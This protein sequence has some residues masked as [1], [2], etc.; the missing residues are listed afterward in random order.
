MPPKP[1][2]KS[3][4]EIAIAAC[5]LEAQLQAVPR[6][7]ARAL[8][9]RLAETFSG[10]PSATWIWEHLTTPHTSRQLEAD[11]ILATLPKLAPDAAQELL[12]FPESD[13]ERKTAFR[14]TLD[15][16]VTALGACHWFEYCITPTDF[17]WLV[18]ENHHD[19]LIAAGEPVAAR[20]DAAWP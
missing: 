3:R 11:D 12:V 2:A 9:Q 15:A 18:C 8:Y 7:E 5:G 1:P 16:I 4:F 13:A 6:E 14:G 19:M 17:Q 10:R 20:L